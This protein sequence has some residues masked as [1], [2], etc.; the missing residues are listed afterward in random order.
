[1][2]SELKAI[3]DFGTVDHFFLSGN[4]SDWL[5]DLRGKL[6]NYPF[7][8]QRGD[9]WFSRNITDLLISQTPEIGLCGK[10]IGVEISNRVHFYTQTSKKEAKIKLDKDGQERLTG[11]DWPSDVLVS[12]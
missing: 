7:G 9:D 4:K 12:D 11:H 6:S 2:L 1:M 3:T 8:L 5:I 10:S